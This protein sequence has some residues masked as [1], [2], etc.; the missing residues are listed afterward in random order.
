[1]NMQQCEARGQPWVLCVLLVV[2]VVCAGSTQA[3]SGDG[4][5]Y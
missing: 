5:K 1:M 4:G 3:P 2:V